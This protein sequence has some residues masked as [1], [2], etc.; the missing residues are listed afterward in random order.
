M[1]QIVYFSTASERQDAIVVAAIL[2][3]SRTHNREQ[4]ISGLLIAGGHRYL[5]V[6]EGSSAAIGRL[7]SAIRADRRHVGVTVMIDQAVEHRS[8]A[9]WSMAYFNEPRFDEF[10][11]VHEL[12]HQLCRNTPDA[13]LLSQA[14]RFAQQLTANPSY[15]PTDPWQT[16]VG[17][18]ERVG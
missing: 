4:G 14:H 13:R 12:I 9:N 15:L 3:V 6:I 1:R 8:F 5:Q 16:R 7:I 17:Y 10:A 2:A 18:P 11:T